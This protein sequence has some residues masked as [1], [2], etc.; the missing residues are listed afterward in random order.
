MKV[1]SA[2]VALVAG[3]SIG[4]EGPTVQIST[5]LFGWI[6]KHTKAK[7]P[8]VDF[9]SYLVAGA[10]AGVAAAFNT[11]L[12]GISFAIEEM[13]EGTFAKI[14]QT[15]MISVILAGITTQAIVGNYVYFG[16]PTIANIDANI[17]V[18]ALI[19][20]VFGGLLGGG[21]AKLLTLTVKFQKKFKWWKKALVCGVIVALMNFLSQGDAAGTGYAITREFM[22]AENPN[23]DYLFPVT[24]LVATVCSYLAGLAGGIFSPS[25]A[26]GAGMGASI[27]DLLSLAPLKACAALGNGRFFHREPFK[28]R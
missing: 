17:I 26:I 2:F 8:H 3:A 19:I 27:G 9:H 13:A 14:K 24:K 18:P 23:V 28:L 22:D 5:A 11:P 12:A 16:R 21:F 6:G 4:R 15:V 1:A 10:A 20:G 25:L 7:Y